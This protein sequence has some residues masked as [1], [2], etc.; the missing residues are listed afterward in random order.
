MR[1]RL[2]NRMGKTEEAKMSAQ[3]AADI[4]AARNKKVSLEP[5]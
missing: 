5:K 1:A 4:I 3:R 2:F